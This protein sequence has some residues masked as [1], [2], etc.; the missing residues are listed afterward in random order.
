[1]SY[2]DCDCRSGAD[3]LMGAEGAKIGQDDVDLDDYN[4]N[5]IRFIHRK[6]LGQYDSRIGYFIYLI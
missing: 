1:M 3:F 6:R 2:H 4:Y 5:K